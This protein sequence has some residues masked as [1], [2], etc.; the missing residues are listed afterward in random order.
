[1]LSQP[2]YVLWNALTTE[3]VSG[4]LH[5]AARSSQAR[6]HRRA[7]APLVV[8]YVLLNQRINNEVEIERI[9]RLFQR[10]YVGV[11]YFLFLFVQNQFAQLIQWR[12][13][14]RLL[15]KSN[16]S[17]P[18]LL[19]FRDISRFRFAI[20][21][22]LRYDR[23]RCLLGLRSVLQ[24][25]YFFPVDSL[26][27]LEIESLEALIGANVEAGHQDLIDGLVKLVAGLLA[28]V[29]FKAAFA[30]IEV[31][32]GPHNDLFDSWFRLLD[33]RLN[34]A[35]GRTCWCLGLNVYG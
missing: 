7:S 22:S 35:S 16:L 8:I 21:S 6:F 20:R 25:W 10:S 17:L 9:L 34:L 14:E 28:P 4:N 27:Q 13:F 2:G 33:F 11:R 19:G 3:R 32:V 29:L 12:W 15:H 24:N 1:D 31:L 30:T 5:E 26:D 23:G 18:W